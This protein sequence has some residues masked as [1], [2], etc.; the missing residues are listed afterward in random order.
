MMEIYDSHELCKHTLEYF[1]DDTYARDL[2]QNGY[3]ESLYE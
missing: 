3:F 2:D 1:Y